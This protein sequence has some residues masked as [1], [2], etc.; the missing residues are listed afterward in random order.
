MMPEII[1]RRPA[2]MVVCSFM[3]ATETSHFTRGDQIHLNAAEGW[4]G[5]GDYSSANQELDLITASLRAAPCVLNLRWGIYSAAKNWPLAAEVAHSLTQF[6]PDDKRGWLHYCDA[7]HQMQ[8]TAEA[9]D[10]LLEVNVCFPDCALMQYNLARYE[11][12]LGNLDRAREHLHAAFTIRGGLHLRPR[13]SNDPDLAPLGGLLS[14]P[15]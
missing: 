13:A 5:L 9:R 8:R 6:D 11:C 2:E 4:L 7:L 15:L 12:R 14:A 10:I 3:I 1:S